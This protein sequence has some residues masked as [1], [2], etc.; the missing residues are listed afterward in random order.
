MHMIHTAIELFI[1]FIALFII[2]KI[3]GKRQLSQITP[4]DFISALVL[5]ELLGNAI[6]D[7]EIGILYVL[8]SMFLWGVLMFVIELVSQKFM[9]TRAFLE[10]NPSIVIRKGKID[11]DELKKNKLDINELLNLLRKK[12]VFSMREVEYAILES[13]GQLS[14][15][16]KSD[17]AAPTRKDLNLPSEPVYLPITFISDGM[18]LWDNIKAKGFNENWLRLQLKDQHIKKFEDVFYAEWL[19]EDGLLIQPFKKN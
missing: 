12:D 4:F 13:D 17:Y 8:F 7:E 2:M 15:L 9:K 3:L 11:R 6:Y 10:G 1:G 19:E 5:G 14:V 18:V 16:K